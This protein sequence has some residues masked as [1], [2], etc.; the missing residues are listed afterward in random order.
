M[1]AYWKFLRPGRVSPFV[2]YRWPEPGVWLE[3]GAVDPCRQGIHACRTADLP[4]WLLDELWQVE[5]AGPVLATAAKV[6]AGRAR[7]VAP[8]AGWDRVA[9]GDFGRACVARVVRHATGELRT[10]GL[11]DQADALA[12]A[13]G[14]ASLGGAGLGGAGLAVTA[15][16][17][18]VEVEQGGHRAAAW[19]CGYAADAVGA[20]DTEP[21][22]AVA[23]IAA[24]AAAHRTAAPGEDLVAAERAWQATWLR[25]RLSLPA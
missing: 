9:A 4:Y 18:A 1:T 5:L 25:D 15:A 23:F 16:E 7:L 11:A 20:L 19:L 21:L 10:A 14:G 22:A 2:G 13:A 8:V 3:A 6:V 12:V 24:R 17:L